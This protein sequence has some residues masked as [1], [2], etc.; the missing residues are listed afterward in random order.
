MADLY[1]PN[2]C[3]NLGRMETQ[4]VYACPGCGY[5]VTGVEL[6]QHRGQHLQQLIDERRIGRAGAIRETDRFQR[7]G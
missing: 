7:A 5:G 3:C 4:D 1:C 6:Q 2:G